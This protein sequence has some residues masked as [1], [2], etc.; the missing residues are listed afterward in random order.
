LVGSQAIAG[1]L[2][3]MAVSAAMAFM[4]FRTCFFPVCWF[5]PARRARLVGCHCAGLQPR[6]QAD[7]G[8]SAYDFRMRPQAVSAAFC[9]CCAAAG[10][11][12]MV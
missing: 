10:S 6:V 1:A 5:R 8:R 7:P 2:A 3:S 4:M 11:A 9:P 12:A